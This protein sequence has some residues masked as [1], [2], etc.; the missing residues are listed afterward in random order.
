MRLDARSTLGERN[1]LKIVE[2]LR[3]YLLWLLVEWRTTS[4]HPK[5]VGGEKPKSKENMQWL[6]KMWRRKRR[7]H[8][9]NVG[10]KNKNRKE[11]YNG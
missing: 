6:M 8:P 10:E 11:I 7:M 4:L 1:G 3:R 5:N 9:K 2:I